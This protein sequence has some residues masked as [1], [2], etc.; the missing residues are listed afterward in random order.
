VDVT[1]EGPVPEIP[2]LPDVHMTVVGPNALRFE[3]YGPIRPL[4]AA[5][6][7]YPIATL[8]SREPSLEE[9]FLH[10]YNSVTGHDR[11]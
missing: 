4:I 6:S 3:V 2:T 5:L 1:F 8:I 7:Q 11:G 10:Q 9:I